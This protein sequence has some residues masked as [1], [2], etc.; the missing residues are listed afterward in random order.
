MRTDH[1]ELDEPPTTDTTA[2]GTRLSAVYSLDNTL[3]PGADTVFV[4]RYT[5][6]A[7]GRIATIITS[8]KRSNGDSTYNAYF[9]NGS[10]TL[11]ER[12]ASYERYSGAMSGTV[13]DTLFISYANGRLVSDSM[14]RQGSGS[15]APFSQWSRYV[16]VGNQVFMYYRKSFDPAITPTDTAI[17]GYLVTPVFTNGNITSQM[18]DSAVYNPQT[19][20]IRTQGRYATLTATYDP[21]PNPMAQIGRAYRIPFL[22][23]EFFAELAADGAI[24]KNLP[25]AAEQSSRAYPGGVVRSENNYTFRTDGL[26]RTRTMRFYEQG[27]WGDWQTFFYLYQ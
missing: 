26:V 15:A 20:S 12:I 4:Q 9:Y 16:Y 25:I 11:A 22:P 18:D 23:I 2:A 27:T 1:Y 10:D 19:Q 7:Q 8:D 21:R 6:D 3:P 24:P 17:L 5:Y 14:V 13:K